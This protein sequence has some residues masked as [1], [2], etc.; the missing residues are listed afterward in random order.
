MDQSSK[1]NFLSFSLT[2]HY[3]LLDRQSNMNNSNVFNRSSANNTS[4]LIGNHRDSGQ[5]D[6]SVT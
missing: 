5:Q 2:H 1:F 6:V 4:L 3:F